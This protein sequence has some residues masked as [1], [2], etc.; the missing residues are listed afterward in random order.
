[1]KQFIDPYEGIEKRPHPAKFSKQLIPHIAEMIPEDCYYICDPMA[2]VGQLLLLHEHYPRGD[3]IFDFNELESEW[4]NQIPKVHPTRSIHCMDAKD[5][6]LAD[7]IDIIIT[8]PPYGNRMADFF[9][10]ETRPESM[11]GRYAGDLGR[12]LTEGSVASQKFGDRYRSNISHIYGNIFDQMRSGSYFLLNVSN[13]IR[14]HKEENVI[15]FYLNLFSEYFHLEEFRKVK[16]PR[17]RGHGANANL[18]V[19][20]EVLILWRKI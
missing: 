20:H 11:K 16:T 9:M 8:S 2:G 6:K 14:N 18:R 19:E 4:V 7:D 3:F 5:Y 1:M 13:F 10:S 17:N 15:G 12:R